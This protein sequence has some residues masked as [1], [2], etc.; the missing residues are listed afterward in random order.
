MHTWRPLNI[1]VGTW[2]MRMLNTLIVSIMLTLRLGSWMG[3]TLFQQPTLPPW[4]PLVLFSPILESDPPTLA[5]TLTHSTHASLV[6][7][8]SKWVTPISYSIDSWY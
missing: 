5:L 6:V 2:T 7:K 4:P 3:T 1:W 8:M